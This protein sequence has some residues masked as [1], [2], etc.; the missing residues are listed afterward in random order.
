MLQFRLKLL[1][2]SGILPAAV[3]MSSQLK[4]LTEFALLFEVDNC[5]E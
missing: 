1:I 3:T 4:S 2:I 5:G